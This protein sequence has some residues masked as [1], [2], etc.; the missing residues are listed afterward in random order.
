MG[1]DGRWSFV[2]F[3]VCFEKDYCI[4]MICLTDITY[5]TDFT[6]L[7]AIMSLTDIT[8]LTDITGLNDVT[9]VTGILLYAFNWKLK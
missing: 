7:T 8:D 1:I 3:V 2:T 9:G 5:L 6:G 4:C